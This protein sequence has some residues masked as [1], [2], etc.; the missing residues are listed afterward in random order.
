MNLVKIRLLPFLFSSNRTVYSQY[1]PYMV[2]KMNRL[3]DDIVACF[4][5]VQFVS[6]PTAGS[7]NDVWFDYV[8]EVTW[9]KALKSSGDI[10]EITPDEQALR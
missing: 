7:F 6:P 4:N 1:I 10:I 9:N 8:L 5:N 3:P 2:L